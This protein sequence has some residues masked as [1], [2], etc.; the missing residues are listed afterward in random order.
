ML[1]GFDLKE[2]WEAVEEWVFAN[3]QIVIISLV[4][5]LLIGG[6][7]FI[8][9]S[10]VFEP[11]KVE[12]LDN[13]QIAGASASGQKLVVEIAGAVEKPGVYNLEADARVDEL[14]VAAG[15]LSASADRDWVAKNLN[16]AAKVVDGQKIYIPSKGSKESM[17]GM[18][19]NTPNDPNYSNVPN[20]LNI[21][22]ASQGQL[23]GLPGIGEVRAQAIISTAW[24]CNATVA[25]SWMGEGR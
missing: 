22:S 4:G 7:L 17:G 18:G 5:I 16:R 9:S 23:E 12:I 21:N 24:R 11:T 6:G 15:G 14:L 20:L 25:R 19:I 13:S 2:R 10:G 1:G 3:R 8:Y